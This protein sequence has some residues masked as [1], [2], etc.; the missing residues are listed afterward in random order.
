VSG[1]FRRVTMY[2]E[3]GPVSNDLAVLPPSV[4]SR[5]LDVAQWSTLC[6]SLFPGA[7][8][9]SVLMAVDYCKARGLDIMKKPCHIVPISVKDGDGWKYRDVVMP[10]IYEYRIT[11]HRTKEYMGHSKPEYGPTEEFGGVHAPAWCEMVIKRLHSET[12]T[13][14]EYPVRVYFSEVCA[15]K[16]GKANQRWGKAPIQMLTKCCE[17]A[18]LREAFPDELGGTQTDD[19]MYGRVID[20]E[21]VAEPK[22]EEKRR[23]RKP[24]VEEPQ[25]KGEP[26][27]ETPSD[28]LDG[29]GRDRIIKSQQT[30][31]EQR[32][33]RANIPES[34]FCAR[35]EI[36]AISEL[37][38]DDMQSAS[39]WIAQQ[40]AQK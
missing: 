38:F 21:V 30:L 29:Q 12:T 3:D 22:A 31:I 8:A 1:D 40:G 13:I 19:E 17:A 10:G 23:S 25:A 37:L 18:G 4:T 6:N 27:P 9:E 5:G 24:Q 7:K 26:A 11:A 16:D 28:G 14:V 15:I 33:K 20:A 39:E 2:D 35:F 32:L 34:E 36:G